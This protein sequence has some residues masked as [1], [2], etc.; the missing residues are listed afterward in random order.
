MVLDVLR[1]R[2]LLAGMLLSLLAA[3]PASAASDET[4]AGL[5][6]ETPYLADVEPQSVIVYDFE[7]TSVDE[8]R[9]GKGFADTIR[10]HVDASGDDAAQRTATLDVFS[11][12]RE[13]KIGPLPRTQ[14][15]PVLMVIL[16]QDTFELQRATGGQPAYFRNRIRAALRDKATIAKETIAFGGADAAAHRITIMPYKGDANFAKVPE[17]ADTVYEFVVSEKVPGGI[18]SITSTVPAPEGNGKTLKKK[19]MAFS[20]VKKM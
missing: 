15:N 13:R 20:E 10:L 18:L 5:L 19:V 12:Q 4:A 16:E 9:F 6:F 14:G 8:T 3:S 11:G 7:L 1:S 17:I 2:A